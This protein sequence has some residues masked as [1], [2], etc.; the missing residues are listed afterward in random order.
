MQYDFIKNRSKQ[1][2]FKKNTS[3]TTDF[4]RSK[5]LSLFQRDNSCT[6]FYCKVFQHIVL[7][8]YLDFGKNYPFIKN[9]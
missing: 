7:Q 1:Q 5:L 6:L 9:I 2:C 8:K 4:P 3:K